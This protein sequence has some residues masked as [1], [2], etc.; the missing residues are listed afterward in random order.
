MQIS[1]SQEKEQK[2]IDTTNKMINWLKTELETAPAT[3]NLGPGER[4]TDSKKLINKVVTTLEAYLQ[5]RNYG[6]MFAS[7]Y[8]L[9]FRIRTA[10]RAQKNK[11]DKLSERD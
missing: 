7:E 8:N 5:K 6:Q 4:V 10:L 9:A 3:F 2:I 1:T 11:N